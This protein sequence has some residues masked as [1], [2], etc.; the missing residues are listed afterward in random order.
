MLLTAFGALKDSDAGQK[1]IAENHTLM[2]ALLLA[3]V[4]FFLVVLLST[5][6]QHHFEYLSSSSTFLAILLIL[7]LVD[8]LSVLALTLLSRTAR[9]SHFELMGDY[10]YG[11]CPVP[12]PKSAYC[13]CIVGKNQEVDGEI[14]TTVGSYQ[15]KSKM[16]SKLQGHGPLLPLSS[17]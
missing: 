7:I 4:A 16:G 12:L 2:T 5:M 8:V 3:F 13:Q 6:L 11:S 15:N 17:V 1:L 9:Y 10:N 14:Q